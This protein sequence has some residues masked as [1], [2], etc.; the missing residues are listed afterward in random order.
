MAIS[1]PAFYQP[2]IPIRPTSKIFITELNNLEITSVGV[3]VYSLI[4]STATMF[5]SKSDVIRTAQF[6]VCVIYKS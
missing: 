1:H 5:V 4:R 3:S 6:N 2:M